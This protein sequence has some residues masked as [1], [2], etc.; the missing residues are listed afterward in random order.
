[1]NNLST[2]FQIPLIRFAV[3]LIIIVGFTLNMVQFYR[4]WQVN[5]A[6]EQQKT[7][8]EIWNDLTT[9]EAY[10]RSNLYAEKYSKDKN[11]RKIGEEVI[12]TSSIEEI[13]RPS[14]EEIIYAPASLVNQ[15]SNL[16]KWWECFFG[17]NRDEC[18]K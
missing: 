8:L 12:D 1:M 9:H 2:F 18:V 11:Y 7:T 10:L 6:I 15:K 16:E 5:V 17:N 4:V 14:Q 13:Y 3:H